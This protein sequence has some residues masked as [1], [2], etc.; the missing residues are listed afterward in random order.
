MQTIRFLAF[1]KSKLISSKNPGFNP[2]FFDIVKLVSTHFHLRV[3][4]SMGVDCLT[5]LNSS[6]NHQQSH[7][8]GF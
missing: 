5:V 2:G 1:S 7:L 6:E 8:T 3:L 4:D